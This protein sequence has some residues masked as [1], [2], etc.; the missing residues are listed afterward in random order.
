MS[1][2]NAKPTV[3]FYGPNS[4]SVENLLHKLS[5][6]KWFTAV[7]QPLTLPMTYRGVKSYEEGISLLPETNA[8]YL[9]AVR[10][11][12]T[13]RHEVAK[14]HSSIAWSK[15]AKD[16]RNRAFDIVMHEVV[17]PL[18][19]NDDVRGK[20]AVIAADSASDL[21]YRGFSPIEIRYGLE[22]LALYEM[23][24]WP[25]G[26]DNDGNLIIY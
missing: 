12:K 18:N 5:H 4:E 9:K 11:R 22:V 8:A 17:M 21:V 25:V 7:G 2:S 19:V 24:H 23:G 14:S 13:I 3:E 1:D 6:I 10:L 16:A 20:A 15:F 26:F